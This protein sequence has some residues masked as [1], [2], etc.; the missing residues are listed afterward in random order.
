MVLKTAKLLIAII[1]LCLGSAAFAED[2]VYYGTGSTGTE[3]YYD[4]ETIRKFKGDIVYV[5]MTA[6]E[7]KNK[8]VPYRRAMV[9][10]RFNCSNE[11]SGSLSFIAYRADGTVA[12]SSSTTSPEMTPI[13]PGSMNQKLFKI[14]CSK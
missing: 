7:S 2:L 4:A 8:T 3:Y 6:D 13:I 5:W 11:T 10:W 9:M 1:G 12:D 14:V